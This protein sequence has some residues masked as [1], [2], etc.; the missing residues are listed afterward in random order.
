MARPSFEFDRRGFLKTAGGA[1]LST[2][3]PV[4]SLAAPEPNSGPSPTMTSISGELAAWASSLRFEALSAEAVHHT[5]R[6][7]LDALG[8]A[9]GGYRQPEVAVALDVLDEVAAPGPATVIG[10][11]RRTD[12]VSAS[13]ANALMVR[14]MDY[15]DLYWKQDP[16]H[17]SDLIAAA[18]AGAER[19]RGGRRELAVGIALGYELEC[20]MCDAA[21]PGIRE[22]GWH[23]AT[24][25]ALVSPIVTGRMF[26]LA[27][28]KIRH[29]IGISGASHFT[30]GEVTSGKLSMMKGGAD[31]LAI[32]AGVFAALLAEKGYTGPEHI[33]EGKEGLT[34][35]L[36]PRWNLDALTDGLGKSWRIAQCSMK[37]YP[38]EALTQTPI[39]AVLDLVVAHDLTPEGV[40]SV[41]VGTLTRA[42]E[43]LADPSKYHP[44]TKETADHS[45]PYCIATAL[46]NRRVTPAQ[47]T[48]TSIHDPRVQAQLSKITVVADPEIEKAFPAVQRAVV[49]VKMVDGRTFSRTLDFAKGHPRNPLSDREA[50]SRAKLRAGSSRTR[51]WSARTHDGPRAVRGDPRGGGLAARSRRVALRGRPHRRT[52]ARGRAGRGWRGSSA[53]GRDGHGATPRPRLLDG[54]RPAGRSPRPRGVC[55]VG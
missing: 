20:R 28:D 55:P 52:G 43:I 35:C 47:F 3:L 18:L 15:N 45:L 32:K 12:V 51:R 54:T 17:P 34:R 4:L 11:G 31:P 33:I 41:R 13:L 30:A 22:R 6:F 9:L 25:T 21:F 38:T 29:A 7:L 26:R 40:A 8:C 42:A 49:E 5:K 1:V 16:S 53:A 24:F 36:G 14:A 48:E 23:H 37:Y 44:Q 46:V 27:P 39:S 19:A 2:A 10:S 50:T